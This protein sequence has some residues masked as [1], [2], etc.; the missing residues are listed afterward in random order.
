[1]GAKI[2]RKIE[3]I[4]APISSGDQIEIITS[5]NV[6]PKPEWLEHV[7]TTKAKQAIMN[8][9]KKDKL[10]NIANGI[11][12]FEGAP[13][14]FRGRRRAPACSARCC[15]P[16]NAR[17]KDE[18]YSKLGAG[19]VPLGRNLGKVLRENSASKILKFWSLQ[20]PNPFKFLGRGRQ[21]KGK[22][23]SDGASPDGDDADGPAVRRSPR[24][25]IRY[26]ATR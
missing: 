9:L 6:S 12:L 17:T 20:I 21:E 16:T 11:V 5:K 14:G 3:S 22:S 23:V 24:A 13:E 8:R 4:F 15:R 25:A 1:M 26:R 2:N 19:I 18:F 10:N 7:I